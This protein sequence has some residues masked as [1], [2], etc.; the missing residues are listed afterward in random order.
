MEVGG[1]SRSPGSGDS[2]ERRG[3]RE[4]AGGASRGAPDLGG[5]T[6]SGQEARV[7]SS[8][9]QRRP[10]EERGRRRGELGFRTSEGSS[11]N[12]RRMDCGLIH[13]YLKDFFA[14]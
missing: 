1:R 13:R 12:L 7:A 10:G 3:R 5:S 11:A 2:V 6:A 8:E 14:N 9:L 4:E